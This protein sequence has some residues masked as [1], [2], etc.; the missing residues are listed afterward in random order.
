M[1]ENSKSVHD[2]VSSSVVLVQTSI[3]DYRQAVIDLLCAR[4]GDDFKIFAGD[5]YFDPSTRTRIVCPKNLTPIR[6]TF[7]LDRRLLFQ[8]GMFRDAI[9][10]R[11]AILELNPR[12]LSVWVILFVRK[13]L[14]RRSVLWGHAWARSGRGART[15]PVRHLMRLMA[16]VILLYTESQKKELREKMPRA[17]LIAAPNALY[18]ASKMGLAI[19]PVNPE[20]FIYVGRLVPEKRPVLLLKAFIQ[21]LPQLSP[22]ANLIVVGDGPERGEL[23]SIINSTGVHDRVSLLGHIADYERLRE[24]YGTALFSVSPGY[25]GL[26]ITQS[27]AFGVPMIVADNEPHAPE[28][29]AAVD[30]ENALFF[31]AGSVSALS[32]ALISVSRCPA[33]WISRREAIVEAC[34]R[35]Y[36]AEVMAD[37]IIESVS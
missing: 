32:D 11:A 23:E 4:L 27:F 16:D 6:N 19:S 14:G 15:E 13:L 26:S 34:R 24:L 28:I 35:N 31:A 33:E 2:K 17:L 25:V 7:L 10:A 8:S 12:I 21:A 29:E 1:L 3:G 18:P 22:R 9:R 5:E 36:S 37:K 20:S 30:G